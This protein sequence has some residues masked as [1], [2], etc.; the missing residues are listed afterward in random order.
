MG[1]LR[2]QDR[3]NA[4]LEKAVSIP[5]VLMLGVEIGA[6]VPQPGV[7]DDSDD[8]CLWPKAF[9]DTQCCTRVSP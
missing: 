2:N 4:R 5:L 6:Q 9:G 3:E 1:C 8:G 7:D